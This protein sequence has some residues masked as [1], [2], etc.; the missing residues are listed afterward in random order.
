MCGHAEL[1]TL[2]HNTS[3]AERKSRDEAVAQA[4][5]D[6]GWVGPPRGQSNA[7]LLAQEDAW[8][9]IESVQRALNAER[10]ASAA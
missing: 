8:D 5:C 4:H 3:I 1:M 10:L 7:H 6:C 2:V 9:H